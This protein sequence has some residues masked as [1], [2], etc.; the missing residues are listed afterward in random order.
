MKI[1]CF[2][3][4]H[5]EIEVTLSHTNH[6]QNVPCPTMLTRAKDSILLLIITNNHKTAWERSRRFLGK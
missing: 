4:N 2:R 1:N 3:E 6:L 5:N